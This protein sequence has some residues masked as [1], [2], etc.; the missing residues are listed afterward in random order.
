MSEQQSP[1][2]EDLFYQS[3]DGLT[4]YARDYPAPASG[5]QCVLLMHGLSRNSRDFE[6]LAER[7]SKRY[8]VL[9]A[10]QRG[11][12]KSDWDAD[13]TRYA[14]PQYVR[15]MFALLKAAN[16]SRVATVGTS[17]GGLMAMVMNSAMP[18]VFSH[19]VLN[20]IGPELCDEGLNRIKGYVGQ[21]EP[22]TSWAEAVAY[23]RRINEV[24]FPTL[25]DEGW[26]Q[27]ARQIFKEVN[28]VPV[29]DYDP[30]ISEAVNADDSDAVPPNLWPVFDLLAQQPLMLIR[31]AL[32]DLLDTRITAEMKRR[33]P[34]MAYLEVA[35]VGHAP[36]LKDEAVIAAIEAFFNQ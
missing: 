15:D 28:G 30:R 32:S 13:P 24:A 36:M 14:I 22:V 35:D 7:L 31:G 26:E 25:S 29:L 23:N 21:G 4:L 1:N 11:R 5:A 12:G 17:M 16:V 34:A 10:E 18:G 33:V 19:V 2:Y 9:V 3:E 6:A 8:R 27:F 20:D